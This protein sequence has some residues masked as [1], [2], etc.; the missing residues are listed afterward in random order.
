[1]LV[2]RG[3]GSQTRDTPS[4]YCLG[5][6]S[7][8]RAAGAAHR[9]CALLGWHRQQ[10]RSRCQHVPDC[11]ETQWW[12]SGNKSSS[13]FHAG[14]G[15]VAAS[16]SLSQEEGLLPCPPPGRLTPKNL[17]PRQTSR[18]PAATSSFPVAISQYWTARLHHRIS[19]VGEPAAHRAPPAP[20][21]PD[22]PVPAGWHRRDT[23]KI[24]P[25]GL[26][27]R[28]EVAAVSEQRPRGLLGTGSVYQHWGTHRLHQGDASTGL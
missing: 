17:F 9:G 8:N 18:P 28:G 21:L 27:T 14:P 3:A 6:D 11:S 24:V 19:G 20:E 16:C 10:D 26:M 12:S 5:E 15:D 13:P 22:V 23:A 1:M 2:L 25:R 4:S 7:R